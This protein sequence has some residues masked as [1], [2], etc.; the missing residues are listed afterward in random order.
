MRSQLREEGNLQGDMGE[1]RFAVVAN[2]K[3][4]AHGD[5]VGRQ[6]GDERPSQNR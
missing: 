4:G 6:G 5:M 3:E 1:G 2:G